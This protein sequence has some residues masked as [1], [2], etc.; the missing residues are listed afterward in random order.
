ME[1]VK[2]LHWHE[3]AIPKA[4]GLSVSTSML[5][6]LGTILPCPIPQYGSGV[7]SEPPRSGQWNLRNKRFL[8]AE[9]FRS[10]G[11]LYLPGG[12]H[13]VDEKDVMSFARA[14]TMSFGTVGMKTPEKPPSMLKGNPQGSLKEE[15]SNLLAKIGNSFG[16]KPEIFLFLIHEHANPAIYKALK[17]ICEVQHGIPS[18]V[19]VVE[20]ALR[21]KGQQQYL[22]N[23]SLKVSQYQS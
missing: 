1:N 8:K 17:N 13:H 5:Q 20:K 19:M 4:M 12:H 2:R 14:I 6:I 9:G 11:V 16:R 7:D 10:W 18:Q 15:V 22:G 21:S 3:L 23:I